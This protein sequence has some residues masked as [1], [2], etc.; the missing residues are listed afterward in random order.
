M[1]IGRGRVG[2]EIGTGLG[3]LD[4]QRSC[5]LGFGR[6]GHC[7]VMWRAGG[8][9]WP[10][11][12]GWCGQPAGQI[13]WVDRGS[14]RDGGQGLQRLDFGPMQRIADDRISDAKGRRRLESGRSRGLPQGRRCVDGHAL[15]DGGCRP[16][17]GRWRRAQD[18][19]RGSG[20]SPERRRG[21]DFGR[22][23][24][25]GQRFGDRQSARGNGRLGGNNVGHYLARRSLESDQGV[26]PGRP[27]RRGSRLTQ[28]RLQQW[29]QS[30]RFGAVAACGFW[31]RQCGREPDGS[32]WS[33]HRSAVFWQRGQHSRGRLARWRLGQHH[34]GR[35]VTWHLRHHVRG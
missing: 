15:N 20:F 22:G 26:G 23:T 13:Q 8:Q 2:N 21:C 33:V 3:R 12:F 28:G 4:C 16:I 1:N 5:V 25:K 10:F 11:R 19:A 29:R 30:G 31:Q 6:N 27:D 18:D 9:L 32:D 34:R 7:A 35:L 24:G 17:Q 14:G